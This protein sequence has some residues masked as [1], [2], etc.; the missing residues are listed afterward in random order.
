MSIIIVGNVLKDV[1]L[2]L[3]NRTESFES[4]KHGTKWFDLS[5][6]ASEHYF[7]SRE[8][9]LGG[10]AISLEVLS[11][12]GLPATITG[13]NLQPT[14][15][16]LT[17]NGPAETYRYILITDGGASY[18]TPTR[19]V[20]TTFDPPAEPVDYLYIDRSANL[21]PTAA[22]VLAAMD[23]PREPTT[24]ATEAVTTASVGSVR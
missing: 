20:V 5:F 12:L 22:A 1:Y 14:P 19:H 7:F 24:T 18:F 16:G 13:S 23:T 11:K 17:A 10:A 9:N 3:D 2:N 4:D 21:D 8:A 6:N 15:D